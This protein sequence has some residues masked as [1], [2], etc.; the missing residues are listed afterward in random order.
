MRGFRD[1][2][3]SDGRKRWLHSIS[4]LAKWT[5]WMSNALYMN[6]PDLARS[7]AARA[8]S[9][10]IRPSLGAHDG[11]PIADAARACHNSTV[12]AQCL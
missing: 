9:C 3:D 1:D 2:F 5:D 6:D 10:T 12:D 11:S 4:S 8:S 7:R